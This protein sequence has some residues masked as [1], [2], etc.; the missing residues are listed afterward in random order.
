MIEWCA[1]TLVPVIV[2]GVSPVD[3]NTGW[4]VAHT[5]DGGVLAS[6]CAAV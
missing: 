2:A 3:L 1:S 4:D 5:V 6:A